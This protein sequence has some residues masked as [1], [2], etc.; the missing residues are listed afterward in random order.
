ML[1]SRC[2]L[3]SVKLFKAG[4]LHCVTH[5]ANVL[6]NRCL[7]FVN[8]CALGCLQGQTFNH[9][10]PLVRSFDYLGNLKTGGATF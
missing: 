1:N 4:Y 3:A 7:S 5:V 9:L 8:D 10:Q 6:P 2:N